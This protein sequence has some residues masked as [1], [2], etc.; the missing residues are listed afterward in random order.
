MRSSV[1]RRARAPVLWGRKPPKENAPP[2]NPH[3]ATAEVTADGPGTTVTG[4]PAKRHADLALMCDI[5]IAAYDASFEDTAHVHH[6]SIVP[7]DE[8]L[9]DGI[10][11][12]KSIGSGYALGSFWARDR[13]L[14]ASFSNISGSVSNAKDMGL[15]TEPSRLATI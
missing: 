15:E 13:V 12:A 9:P 1:C 3:S 2:V 4:R 8:I 6:G 7:G 10:S 11:W 5:V 14:L